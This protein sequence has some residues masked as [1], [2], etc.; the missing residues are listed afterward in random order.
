MNPSLATTC[1]RVACWE[2]TLFFYAALNSETIREIPNDDLKATGLRR[3]SVR[4][5]FSEQK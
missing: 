3:H 2:L 5:K 1:N 4:D